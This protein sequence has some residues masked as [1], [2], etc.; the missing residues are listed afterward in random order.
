MLR[1]QVLV[2]CNERG[3]SVVHRVPLMR[4]NQLGL[5]KRVLSPSRHASSANSTTVTSTAPREAPARITSTPPPTVTLVQVLEWQGGTLQTD[6]AKGAAAL[7]A[8]V[9]AVYGI[10]R[11]ITAKMDTKFDKLDT[12]IDGVKRDL[13]TKIDAKIDAL[14]T[15]VDAK[16]DALSRDMKS[17]AEELRA[18]NFKLASR[19]TV[20][21]AFTTL[22]SLAGVVAF[23]ASGWFPTTSGSHGGPH[24]NVNHLQAPSQVPA[25]GAGRAAAVLEGSHSLGSGGGEGVASVATASAWEPGLGGIL[26]NGV[27]TVATSMF[28]QA[29]RS[30]RRFAAGG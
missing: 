7:V 21:N 13:D 10:S 23:G 30:L 17:F 24:G 3:M 1:S 12:K 14:E 18:Q 22:A 11:D 25:A 15:K 29:W 5:G 2:V 4:S 27:R 8:G 26:V 6:W 19:N 28:E 9:G 20:L 16:I